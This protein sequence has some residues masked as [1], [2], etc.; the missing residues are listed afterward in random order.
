MEKSTHKRFRFLQERKKM[1]KS[2]R[3][4]VLSSLILVFLLT[5]LLIARAQLV[6]PVTASNGVTADFGTTQNSA[7]SFTS[8]TQQANTTNSSSTSSTSGNITVDFG[9][10]NNHAHPIPST[11][12]GVGG[13]GIGIA[14]NHAGSY[15]PQAG[16][17]LA[18]LGD[19]DY[20]SQIFPTS[21]SL[22][23][24][25]QQNWTLLDSQL[26][27]VTAYNLQPMISLGYTPNWLQP[28]N[29]SPKQTNP[30]L[31]NNPPYNPAS[32]KPMYLVNGH[33]VGTQTWGKLA[34]LVVAHVD[35]QFPRLHTLYEIWNQPDG[36]QFLCMP[37]GDQNA[38]QDRVTAYKAIF[39]AAAPLM[40]QQANGDGAQI[41]IGGPALVY[42]LQ[43]HLTMWFS[44]LLND[45]AIYPYI[46]F[47]SYH[48][49][50]YGSNFNSGGDK[51]LVG[52]A[53]DPLLGVASQ[54]E[55]VS[56]AVHAGKQPNAATTPI[57][58]DEYNMNS[59]EPN[60][61][62]NDPTLAP[63]NNGLFMVDL[64]NTVN[65][66]RS[67]YGASRAVP[68]GLAFYS[69][70]IPQG[71]LCMF[72]VVD[73][74]MDCGTPKGGTFQPYP[75]YYAYQLL[76][77]ANYL[78]ITDGGYVANAASANSSGVLTTGFYTRT[79]NSIVLVN[80]TGTDYSALRVLAQNPGLVSGTKAN[81]YT[82]KVNL[83]Q[84]TNCIST[85]QVNLVSGSNGSSM[86]VHLPPY[87]MM[88]I[89]FK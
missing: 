67:S 41:K 40:R 17:R 8:Q 63:L 5:G 77:G 48:R 12:L 88:G 37:Q 56:R 76:G 54:Y 55:Q 74:R 47:V 35:H 53:Q 68:A 69:W 39:A 33:D 82:V 89:S 14:L 84:P 36:G 60:V 19:T 23:T 58:L 86:T 22:T 46:D 85:T 42:A 79:Q 20:M 38:D 70:N 11:F 16:L 59:C 9:S 75:S 29:Q 25:S 26:A 2:T 24:S 50:L 10:R 45:P 27:L 62:R 15:V 13:I 31:T 32:V 80:T 64:L 81:V 57:Y 65:D 7:F 78:N 1:S 66:T 51:S 4:L 87:T 49:Y 44:S 72:G 34:A 28:Q 30:C 83:N 61:C 73:S 52:N 21:A 18:K 3:M 43:S 71:N 6:T